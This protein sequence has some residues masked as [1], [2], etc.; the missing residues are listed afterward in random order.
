VRTTV[1]LKAVVESSAVSV[2]THR[3]MLFVDIDG[4]L[5]PYGGPLPEGFE[6]HWL[7]SD[8]DEPVRV[9]KQHSG[10]LHELAQHYDLVW[11]SSWTTPDRALLGT[12]LDLPAFVGA[13]TLPA[14]Q[15]DPAL[16]VPAIDLVAQGRALAWVDDMLSPEAFA[17]A[18]ARD[19][20]TQLITIDPAVGL[21]RAHV[22]RLLD[23]AVE[24]RV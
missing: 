20:P 11:G 10:W 1:R 5:N 18:E 23:W 4:V 14:G 24:L 12:V 3:P 13:V 19:A 15:F 22:D 17:W 9:C 16:K 7:F 21:T 6:E 2:V 8:D